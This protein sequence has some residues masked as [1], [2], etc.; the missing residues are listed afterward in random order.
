MEGHQKSPENGRKAPEFGWQIPQRPKISIGN[1]W[2]YLSSPCMKNI[3]P[4]DRLH[5]TDLPQ[6][7]L[8]GFQILVPK[9]HF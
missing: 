6:I 9:D 3:H 2:S 1:S 4:A 7:G 5:I 8:S